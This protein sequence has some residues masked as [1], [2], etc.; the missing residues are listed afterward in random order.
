MALAKGRK[1]HLGIM[2]MTIC[3]LLAI[4]PAALGFMLANAYADE[5]RDAAE[6]VVLDQSPSM[7]RVDDAQ[8]AQQPQAPSAA[9][10]AESLQGSSGF[11]NASSSDGVPETDSRDDGQD[12]VGVGQ[13]G[14]EDEQLG[15]GEPESA[16]TPGTQPVG[17]STPESS[18]SDSSDV[19]ASSQGV[20][21][22]DEDGA[23]NPDAAGAIQGSAGEAESEDD[24]VAK[25]T[26]QRGSDAQGVTGE[27]AARGADS[28]PSVEQSSG[29]PAQRTVA[30][31]GV[32][33]TDDAPGAGSLPSR[34]DLREEGVVSPV[35]LQS[36]WG[37]C[38]A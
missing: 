27:T 13:G 5:L 12:N 11:S 10:S 9:S 19:A 32:T 8:D 20:G 28:Q 14:Q 23:R 29:M 18:A 21:A 38:W 16:E 22:Y 30:T 26:A 1:P 31:S 17:V 7:D 4:V 2:G 25:L 33:S 37:T 35:K 6:D 36:P 15:D 3:M 24:V 34:F